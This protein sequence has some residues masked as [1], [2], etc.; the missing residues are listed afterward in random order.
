M[1]GIRSQWLAYYY[2]GDV[3][4]TDEN[5]SDIVSEGLKYQL[6]KLPF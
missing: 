1:V 6:K 5:A 2:K 4:D 3:S